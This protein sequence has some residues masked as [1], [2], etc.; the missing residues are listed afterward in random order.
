MCC[1]CCIF[2]GGLYYIVTI[3]YNIVARQGKLPNMHC[4]YAGK[5]PLSF[6]GH[7]PYWEVHTEAVEANTA[8]NRPTG[9]EDMLL[10]FR[11]LSRSVYTF[12]ELQLRPLPDGVNPNKLETYLSDEQFAVSFLLPAITPEFIKSY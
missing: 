4:V 5:E 10:S 1:D 2:S 6:T 8:D 7:F 3:D 9:L 11:Q 12:E